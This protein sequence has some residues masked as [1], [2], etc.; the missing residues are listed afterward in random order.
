[1]AIEE[2]ES[3]ID[4]IL[5][6][7]AQDNLLNDDG[8]DGDIDVVVDPDLTDEPETPET[9]PEAP[10]TPIKEAETVEPPEPPDSTVTDADLEAGDHAYPEPIKKRIKRE[11]RIRK[12]VQEE[13]EQVRS[14]AVQAVQYAQAKD[15]ELTAS[16]EQVRSLQK[17]HAD[18]LD[19]AFDKDIQLKRIALKSAREEGK[20]DDEMAILG[21]LNTLQ[22]QQNQIREVKRTL[23]IAPP[24][25]VQ[26]PVQTPAQ[27]EQ[28]R[29]QPAPLAV[30]WL[31]K[32]D[33]WFN[34]PEYVGH[35][36]FVL[37][38]DAQLVKEGYDKNS[39]QYYS[40][41]DKRVDK[42]FPS[43]RKPSVSAVS[44]PPVAPVG[45]GGAR[46]TPKGTI[47][48]GKD[49]LRNMRKFGL[50]P[51]NKQHLKEYAMSKRTSA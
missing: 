48:L 33:T 2:Q 18:V 34:N 20:S 6:D 22:F 37:G 14:A 39:P 50:D 16:K 13:Y 51:A 29:A 25:Q 35:K 9:P 4:E 19:L 28:P 49:D 11:I 32:N 21:D 44:T 38:V 12:K 15:T 46:V 17:Q 23:S 47:R 7:D 5:A 41:L 24:A 30:A 3:T 36:H 45:A 8:L 31:Q 10:E 43:L 26:T 40:E 1:M 42:A 27:Q